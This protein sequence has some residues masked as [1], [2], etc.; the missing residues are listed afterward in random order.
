MSVD[1]QQALNVLEG[2]RSQDETWRRLDATWKPHIVSSRW[3]LASAEARKRRRGGGNARTS[4]LIVKP[5]KFDWSTF[6]GIT[7]RHIVAV[8]GHNGWVVHGKVRIS[9]PF[10]QH[11]TRRPTRR[12]ELKHSRGSEEPIR[13]SAIVCCMPIF[14][15]SRSV[16]R[17]FQTLQESRSGQGA[18]LPLP[19]SEMR[20]VQMSNQVAAATSHGF[21]TTLQTYILV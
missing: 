9:S 2:L 1:K 11:P 8:A 12:G 18:H 19:S 21:S 7:F 16:S 15:F 5:S 10:C 4:T 3:Q 20:R 13:K 14:L 6:L 17:T